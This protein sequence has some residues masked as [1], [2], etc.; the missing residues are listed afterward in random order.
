MQDNVENWSTG[1]CPGCTSEAFLHFDPTINQQIFIEGFIFNL[2]QFS[3]T[4]FDI[5]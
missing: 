5:I 2:I 4:H 1:N 3:L